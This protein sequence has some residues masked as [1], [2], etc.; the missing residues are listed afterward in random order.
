MPYGVHGNVYNIC[1]LQLSG[2]VVEKKKKVVRFF[3]LMFLLVRKNVL[4]LYASKQ[5]CYGES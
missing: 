1:A 5:F 2:I 3:V 4:T